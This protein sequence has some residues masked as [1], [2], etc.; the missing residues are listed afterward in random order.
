MR[1]AAIA[2]SRRPPALAAAAEGVWIHRSAVAGDAPRAAG[3]R[4]QPGVPHAGGLPT[5]VSAEP[6]LTVIGP[7]TRPFPFHFRPGDEIA[8]GEGQARVGESA[9]PPGA[10]RAPRRED[11][12]SPGDVRL[13]PWLIDRLAA[14][15]SAETAAALLGS[16]LAAALAGDA[17]R[18]GGAGPG[19]RAG[20]T[21]HRSGQ[22]RGRGG[23][24]A[25]LPPPPAPRR[26]AGVGDLAQGLR[27]NDPPQSRDGHGRSLRP[28]RVGASRR[29]IGLLRPVSPG[30]RVPRP[31][32]GSRRAGSISSAAPRPKRPIAGEPEAIS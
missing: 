32:P 13:P 22:R 14:T 12:L 7:K 3:P 4:A 18:A 16:T 25:C 15:D 27:P 19:A 28:A 21:G 9:A 2:S 8:A 6:H 5:V 11:E 31:S 10:G 24:D 26:A 23:P 30:P 29:R 1:S 20:P 17:A